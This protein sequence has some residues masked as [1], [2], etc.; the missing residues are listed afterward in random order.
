MMFFMKKLKLALNLTIFYPK[1]VPIYKKNLKK[2][3][4]FIKIV[5]LI[6]FF[7]L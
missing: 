5:W 2:S 1:I 6:Y 3:K 7:S 4:I